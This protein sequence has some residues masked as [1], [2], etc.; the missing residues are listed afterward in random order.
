MNQLDLIFTPI[1]ILLI[2]FAFPSTR[3]TINS[4]IKI[5][6]RFSIGITKAIIF[7]IIG[8][9]ASIVLV[10]FVMKNYF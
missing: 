3:K 6:F 7:L 1:L 4:I 10:M 5:P 8:Y 2:Y 9:A